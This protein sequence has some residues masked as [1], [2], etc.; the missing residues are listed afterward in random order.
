[1]PFELLNTYIKVGKFLALTPPS[2]EIDKNTKFRQIHQVFMILLIVTCVTLSVYFRNFYLHY[3]LAKSTVC[4]L[5]DILLC[6]FCCRIVVETS[7][8][9]QWIE[10]INCLK[11]TTCLLE[12]TNSGKEKRMQWKFVL[13][14]VIFG[15]VLIYVTY[16]WLSIVGVPQLEQHGFEVLEMYIQFFYTFYVHTILEMIR[17]R[18]EALKHHFKDKLI[19]NDRNFAEMGHFACTLKDAVNKVNYIFG[20]SLLLLTAFTTLQF[21]NYLEYNLQS[22]EFG[23]ENVSQIPTS[24]LLLKC[25]NIVEESEDIIFVVSK[26]GTKLTDPRIREEIDRFGHILATNLPQFSAAR[27]IFLA[28]STILSI[29]GTVATFF[30]VLVTFEPKESSI[31]EAT[32]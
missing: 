31:I 16:Y 25:D 27:F 32:G 30:I 18:Y 21:L 28:R 7:K 8:V 9:S 20:W 22:H 29:F 17:Q 4:F 1:M 23:R 14:Q 24:M 5:T 6:A 26:S 3:N 10:L 19:R 11:N 15:T 13:P 12:E 2:I